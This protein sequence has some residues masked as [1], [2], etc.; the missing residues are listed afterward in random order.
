MGSVQDGIDSDLIGLYT[1]SVGR[2]MFHHYHLSSS[3]IWLFSSTQVPRKG[4]M[5]ERCERRRKGSTSTTTRS[6]ECG[7]TIRRWRPK[8]PSASL[9]HDDDHSQ[10]SS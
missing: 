1:T 2:G 5:L 7:S 10:P 6:H 9:R 4:S 8:R 3:R